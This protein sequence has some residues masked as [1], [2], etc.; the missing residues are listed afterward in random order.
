QPDSRD[1]DF[2]GVPASRWWDAE[3]QR[4]AAVEHEASKEDVHARMLALGYPPAKLH[5]IDGMVQDTVPAHAPEQI[6]V[7]R[8]DTDFYDSTRHELEQLW[9]RISPG[10]ILIVDDYGHFAGA[11]EATD[12]FFAQSGAAP[13]MHRLD[14]SGRLIVK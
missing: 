2:R 11:R 14:Y 10:G 9:P 3:H 12:E 13:Y 4:Q 8:L 7:L 1:I 6:S 5:L